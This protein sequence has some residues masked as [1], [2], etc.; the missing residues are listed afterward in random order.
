MPLG[1]AENVAVGI[2]KSNHT[3]TKIRYLVLR[4][5][6]SLWWLLV[7]VFFL[8]PGGEDSRK[9]GERGLGSNFLKSVKQNL[10]LVMIKFRHLF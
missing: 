5:E 10:M 4:K 9:E 3:E 2:F 8:S 1:A 6:Q 7:W